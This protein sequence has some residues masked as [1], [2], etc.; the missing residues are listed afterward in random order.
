SRV[1]AQAPQ[2]VQQVFQERVHLICGPLA[3]GVP[4]RDRRNRFKMDDPR[5]STL[6]KRSAVG[7][8]R[9]ASGHHPRVRF[10]AMADWPDL[11][12]TQWPQPSRETR[13][14]DVM[15]PECLAAMMQTIVAAAP[16]EPPQENDMTM[17]ALLDA[18]YDGLSKRD[19]WDAP[20]ADDFVFVG[21]NATV[22]S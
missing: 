11:R 21:A 1:L 17:K 2:G 4:A 18:Y 15:C 14:G 19:G 20:L 7:R 9:P 22:D 3:R 5:R 10:R 13:S 12:H 6:R 16:C 8:N